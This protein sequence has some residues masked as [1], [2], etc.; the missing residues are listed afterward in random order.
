M[1]CLSIDNKMKTIEKD[2]KGKRLK[3]MEEIMVDIVGRFGSEVDESGER[4]RD[5]RVGFMVAL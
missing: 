5:G 4:L 3:G 2:L 1:Q